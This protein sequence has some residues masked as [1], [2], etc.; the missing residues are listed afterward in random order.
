[1]I[2]LPFSPPELLLAESAEDWTRFEES[3][4]PYIGE[5]FKVGTEEGG[6]VAVAE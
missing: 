4:P 3:L 5:K 2:N 6:A 1:L